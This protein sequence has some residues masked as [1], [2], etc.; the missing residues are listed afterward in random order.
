MILHASKVA[1]LYGLWDISTMSINELDR[2]SSTVISKETR[3]YF[4]GF[5][6]DPGS[7]SSDPGIVIFGHKNFEQVPKTSMK[8]TAYKVHLSTLFPKRN[9]TFHAHGVFLLRLIVDSR[10]H[11][12]I[13]YLKK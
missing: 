2:L 11:R 10:K 1:S 9:A 13:M 4:T 8:Y 3:H 5:P 7:R 12:A 6:F